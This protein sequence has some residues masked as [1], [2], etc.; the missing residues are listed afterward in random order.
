MKDKIAII[1]LGYVGLP[2]SVE[3]SNFY[4]TIGYD[5]NTNYVR[6][7]SRGID[8]NKILQ[9]QSLLTKKNLRFSS[10]IE[11]IAHYNIYI[12]TVPTPITKSNQPD[13]SFLLTATEMISTILDKGNLVIFEST[14][15]LV[16]Q[17][18]IV[19]QY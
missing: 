19:Y 16:V 14:V 10:L 13:L 6:D 8:K 5:I 4:D 15:F 9:S 7:L 12:I 2:L 3:F 18:N 1:G 11:D 17:R